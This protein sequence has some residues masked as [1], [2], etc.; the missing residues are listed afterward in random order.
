L[1]EPLHCQYNIKL[2]QDAKKKG[3]KTGLA[4]MSY[5]KQ[6]EKILSIMKLED[7]F[8]CI[9][10]R[11]EVKKGKPDP[12]IYLKTLDK[13]KINTDKVAIIED[14]VS[15][16][17][18]AQAAG[19]IVFAVTNSLTREKVN[20]SRILADKF[21]INNSIELNERVFSFINTLVN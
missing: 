5:C 15:G 10:T 2:L 18:A 20:S 1:T 7:H 6:V 9:V 16:I 4:T 21:I 17:E 19:A 14:S 13:L 3:L 8:D 11:D 12:E